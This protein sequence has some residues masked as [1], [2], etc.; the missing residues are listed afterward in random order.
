YRRDRLDEDAIMAMKSSIINDAIPVDGNEPFERL[1]QQLTPTPLSGDIYNVDD[2]I[3]ND[4]NEITGVNEYLR[5][6]PQDISRTATEA[7]II[8]GATNVRTR[9][10]LIQ[11]ETFRSEERRV[12]NEC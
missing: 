4:I 6:V 8:E 9:H 11:V 10:K 7:S 12:G 3:R 5:G 2:I 1:V